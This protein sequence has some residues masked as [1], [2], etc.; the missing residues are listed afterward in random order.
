MSVWYSAQQGY[1]HEVR[2]LLERGEDV[3]QR[4][5]LG[6]SPLVWASRR[7]HVKIVRLLLE[8]GATHAPNRYGSTPLLFASSKGHIEVVH[9]LLD[10]DATHT[11]NE[12]G[13]TPLLGAALHGHHD[14]I[15][16]L[17]QNEAEH[18]KNKKGLT[19]HATKLIPPTRR[20]VLTVVVLCGHRLSAKAQ[21]TPIM[22]TMP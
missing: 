10:A 15:E 9:E 8:Y 4:D 12:T 1:T 6:N 3:N 22:S 20:K 5:T 14:V 21:R 19:K 18:R 11:A 13:D 7:G 17:L 2:E 16:V